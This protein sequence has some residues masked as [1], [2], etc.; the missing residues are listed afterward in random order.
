MS[1]L[2]QRMLRVVR[3]TYNFFVGDMIILLTVLVAFIAAWVLAHLWGGTAG[4]LIG[5]IVFVTLALTAIGLTLGRERAGA[6]KQARTTGH[7]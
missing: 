2:G 7:G 5:G 4:Q 6:R 1:S 3:A